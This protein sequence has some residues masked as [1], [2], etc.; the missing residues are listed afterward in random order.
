MWQRANGNITYTIEQRTEHGSG[1]TSYRTP[2]LGQAL[3]AAVRGRIAVVDRDGSGLEILQPA[4]T[5]RRLAVPIRPRAFSR[6]DIDSHRDSLIAATNRSRMQ[7]PGAVQRIEAVF[8]EKFPV[9]AGEH[10]PIIQHA[11]VV[12]DELWL[13]SAPGAGDGRATWLVMDPRTVRLVGSIAIPREWKVLGGDSQAVVISARD[14]W[15]VEY[16][17]VYTVTR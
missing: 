10:A 17:Q 7:F 4:A 5:S 14:E 2:F 16:V 3:V 8:G 9:P 11:V 13:Q 15:D 6:G 1:L 12:G